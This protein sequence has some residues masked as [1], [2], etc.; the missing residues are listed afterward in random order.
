MSLGEYECTISMQYKSVPCWLKDQ[1]LL[2]YTT[3][4]KENRE[5]FQM[6]VICHMLEETSLGILEPQ[7]IISKSIAAASLN[8]EVIGLD[9]FQKIIPY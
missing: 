7:G 2:N 4:E 9:M 8:V 3:P 6:E 5:T 1:L